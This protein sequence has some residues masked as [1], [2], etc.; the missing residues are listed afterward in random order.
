LGP[1]RWQEAAPWSQNGGRLAEALCQRRAPTLSSYMSGNIVALATPNPIINEVGETEDVMAHDEPPVEIAPGEA[2][3]VVE[4]QWAGFVERMADQA[5]CKDVPSESGDEEAEEESRDSIFICTLN[6]RPKHLMEALV[7]PLGQCCLALESAGHSWKLPT[8]CLV[9]VHPHQYR[10]TMHALCGHD[11]QPSNIVIADSLDYLFQ[12]ALAGL[13]WVKARKPILLA[14]EF[15]PLSLAS[16]GSSESQELGDEAGNPDE[17]EKE[18]ARV[19]H[20][21]FGNDKVNCA[22]VVRRTFLTYVMVPGSATTVVQSTTEA[23]VRKG[24]NPRRQLPGGIDE[25]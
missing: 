19:P 13:T 17:K 20:E 1:A 25:T 21:G 18:T 8:G 7:R 22:I 15:D 14:E 2:R 16:V 6:R 5:P 24:R 9:F 12:E 23:D 11:L 4:L 3:Q 10:K